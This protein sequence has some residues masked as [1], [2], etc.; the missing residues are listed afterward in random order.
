MAPDQSEAE[1]DRHS[2]SD[3]APM[4]PGLAVVD[5]LADVEA[6]MSE[7]ERSTWRQLQKVYRT[8]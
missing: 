4:S 8:T 6:I 5:P 1:R 2:T 3:R 7:E